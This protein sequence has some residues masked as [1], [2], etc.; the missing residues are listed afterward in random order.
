MANKITIWMFLGRSET[1]PTLSV[2][3]TDYDNMCS[4]ASGGEKRNVPELLSKSAFD[5]GITTDYENRFWS[6]ISCCYVPP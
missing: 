6:S 5:V 2:A 1:V 4:L 3:I